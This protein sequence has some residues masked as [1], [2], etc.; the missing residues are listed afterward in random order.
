[1]AE[2]ITEIHPDEIETKGYNEIVKVTQY[3]WSQVFDD[4]NAPI[5]NATDDAAADSAQA[6]ADAAQGDATS[7]INSLTDIAADT[8]ITPVEKLTA[9]QLW[10]AIVVEGTATTGTIP[11]AAIAL[12]VS[13][14]NF[15]TDY[16]SLN[17]YLNT[18]LSVF[19]NMAT[20]TTVIRA[21]WDTAWKNYYD[22]RTKI[23]NAIATA[24]SLI[25]NWSTVVDDDTNKPDDN[26]DVTGDNQ[27]DISGSNIN[28]DSGWKDGDEV[29]TIVGNTITAAYIN[30]LEITALGAVTSGSFALGSNAW[31]VDTNGNMWWGDF[32]NYASASIKISAAGAINFASGTFGS[33]I[34]TTGENVEQNDLLCFGHQ[35]T[36]TGTNITKDSYIAEAAADDD[37]NYGTASLMKIGL[38]AADKQWQA[39]I[40]FN[41]SPLIAADDVT[42]VKLKFNIYDVSN[43]GGTDT[44]TLGTRRITETWGEETVTWN[45]MPT[46]VDSE[47]GAVVINSTG[48]KEI[49]ITNMYKKWKDGTANYGFYLKVASSSVTTQPAY[50]R[51]RCLEDPS[52][53]YRENLYI[54]G[55]VDRDNIY[56]A[57]STLWE[58]SE[59][60]GFAGATVT[61]G[62]DVQVHNMGNMPGFTLT[63]GKTYYASATPGNIS[64]AITDGRRVGVALT[65]TILNIQ[66]ITGALKYIE[67]VPIAWSHPSASSTWE[68]WD[69]SSYIPYGAKSA[70]VIIWNAT[71]DDVGVRQRGATDVLARYIAGVSETRATSFH[72]NV[73]LDNRNIIERYGMA[74]VNTKFTVVGYWT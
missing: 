57:D 44:I 1:M 54:T 11:A 73:N 47:D 29:A 32:A 62:N 59:I 42:S 41:V 50:L 26:A 56:M 22:E 46:S 67:I 43:L 8:K 33:V 55:R 7:A 38:D 5:D 9:K 14:T 53:G 48:Y 6:A 35:G 28:N 40:W 65:S 27:G 23:L 45:N 24:A 71:D 66:T 63:K 61:S 69:L 36:E 51:I 72:F 68:E 16:A 10:D 12:S 74:S 39:L 52:P 60:A 64:D 31:H 21:D 37:T 15:D 20:S 30:A 18:T 70:D 25:A 4:G 2:K 34:Y 17:T 3:P 13:T 49:D 58:N 19:N